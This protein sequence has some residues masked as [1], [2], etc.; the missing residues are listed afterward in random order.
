MEKSKIVAA[1]LNWDNFSAS[2]GWVSRFK[3]RHVLVFKKLAGES[4]E[5]SVEYLKVCHPYWRVMNHAMYTMQMRRGYPST[6]FLIEPSHIKENLAMAENISRTDSLCYYV[7]I[8]MDV[9]N[10]CRS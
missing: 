9:I 6:C 4:A 10:K 2:S 5:V 7:L 1:Q 8:V 3:D